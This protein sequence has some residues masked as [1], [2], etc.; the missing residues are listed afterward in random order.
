MRTIQAASTTGIVLLKKKKQKQT[1][2]ND[3]TIHKESDR[4]SRERLRRETDEWQAEE[5]ASC[6][7]T[8]TKASKQTKKSSLS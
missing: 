3:N 8:E 5:N 7:K 6:E 2:T 1:K 4:I